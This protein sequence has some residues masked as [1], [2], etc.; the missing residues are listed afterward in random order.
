M[1]KYFKNLELEHVYREF[2]KE[3][4][5]LAKTKLQE[6]ISLKEEVNNTMDILPCI[7]EQYNVVLD[8]EF[9]A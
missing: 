1:I 9:S 4:D 3:A 7:I 8:D 6:Y 5:T 2:N